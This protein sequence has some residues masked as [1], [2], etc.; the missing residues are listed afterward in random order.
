MKPF[1]SQQ[2][3]WATGSLSL[4]KDRTFYRDARVGF[5]RLLPYV[6]G[7]LYYI[8]TGLAV[9]VAPIPGPVMMWCFPD[10]VQPQNY[11][12]LIGGPLVWFIVLPLVSNCRWRVETLRVQMLYSFAHAKALYDSLRNRT[13]GWVPTGAKRSPNPVAAVVM[14]MIRLVIPVNIA[15]MT[16]GVLH[17]SLLYGFD[18]VWPAAVYALLYIYVAAPLLFAP[19]VKSWRSILSTARAHVP[20][21]RTLG[22]DAGREA[23]PA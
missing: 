13:A 2:Y 7:F 12:P 16:T 18:K 3:R 23:V 14:R 19:Q 8:T 4:M 15:A 22:R 10:M 17:V 6:S 11:L 9:F 5:R 20:A 21:V 1:I